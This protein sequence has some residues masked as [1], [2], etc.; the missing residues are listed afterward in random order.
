MFSPHRKDFFN[1]SSFYLTTNCSSIQLLLEKILFYHSSFYFNNAICIFSGGYVRGE[2]SGGNVLDPKNM[3]LE[4]GVSDD[5]RDNLVVCRGLT[6]NVYIIKR[7]FTGRTV[8]CP[9]ALRAD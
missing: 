5:R 7:I 1:Q 9:Y 4:K 6:T 8:G 3:K 2:M